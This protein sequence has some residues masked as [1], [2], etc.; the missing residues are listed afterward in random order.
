MYYIALNELHNMST[1]R[2]RLYREMRNAFGGGAPVSQERVLELGRG[3]GLPDAVTNYEYVACKYAGF[4]EADETAERLSMRALTEFQQYDDDFRY[5]L[6]EIPLTVE[7]Y[8]NCLE[9]TLNRVDTIDQCCEEQLLRRKWSRN[10]TKQRFRRKA[11][12][13]EEFRCA[14]AGLVEI[15]VDRGAFEG[16]P[17]TL[18][19]TCGSRR[20]NTKDW[21]AWMNFRGCY[22]SETLE[23]YRPVYSAIFDYTHKAVE[24]GGKEL[25][26]Q[27]LTELC[28]KQGEN[29]ETFIA[30]ALADGMLRSLGGDRYAITGN[31]GTIC[32]CC[33]NDLHL[34]RLDL[35]I[36]KAKTGRLNL[37]IAGN[38]LFAPGILTA[39]DSG[40][41]ETQNHWRIHEADS[42]E[43][44]LARLEAILYSFERYEG[45][46]YPGRLEE[47]I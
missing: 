20:F 4:I 29:G 45:L 33:R 9:L 47:L 35:V 1:S 12:S 30:Q 34:G 14:A 8:P 32:R 24:W 43:Q 2:I 18:I 46:R 16:R 19:E 36:R 23:R 10:K 11:N 25:T 21:A 26:W 39:V 15:F 31:A 17:E 6:S 7:L 40:A 44:V 3:L 38:S 27:Q 22:A 13:F 28:A 37:Y 41:K 5:K 42:L